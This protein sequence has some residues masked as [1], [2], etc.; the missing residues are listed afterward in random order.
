MEDFEVL[1][2]VQGKALVDDALT[3][4]KPETHISRDAAAE[5]GAQALAQ[6]QRELLLDA[7]DDPQPVRRVI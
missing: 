1:A 4:P 6:S 5:R 2:L 7:A 3:A